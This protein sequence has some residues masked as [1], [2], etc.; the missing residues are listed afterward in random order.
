MGYFSAHLLLAF[1]ASTNVLVDEKNP[2]HVSRCETR[3]VT[4]SRYTLM[5]SPIKAKYSGK[6]KR[7][8][9]EECVRADEL[10]RKTNEEEPSRAVRERSSASVARKNPGRCYSWCELSHDGFIMQQRTLPVVS[11][12]LRL[13]LPGS[14]RQISERLA[15]KLKIN[16]FELLYYNIQLLYTKANNKKL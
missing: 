5:P 1:L 6:K 7:S 2:V 14:I 11:S 4:S 10:E 13:C 16:V 12:T 9:K 3:P 8:I 15:G